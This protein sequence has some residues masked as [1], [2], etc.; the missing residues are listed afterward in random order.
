M[1]CFNIHTL[2]ADDRFVSGA[3]LSSI[4]SIIDAT[5][6]LLCCAIFC[7]SVMNSDSSEI[8]V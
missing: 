8:L 5:D 1:Y 7:S 3:R 4:C 2:I 6:F